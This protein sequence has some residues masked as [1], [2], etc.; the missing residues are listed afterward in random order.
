M[1]VYSKRYPAGTVFLLENGP[2]R[3]IDGKDTVIAL[4]LCSF[5]SRIVSRTK[6]LAQKVQCSRC[7][8]TPKSFMRAHSG[9]QGDH[10]SGFGMGRWILPIRMYKRAMRL[11]YEG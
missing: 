11:H 9:I 4:C 8:L 10:Q 3:S 5:C 2:S 7:K 6:V 1:L